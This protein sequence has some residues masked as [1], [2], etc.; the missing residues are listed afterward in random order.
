MPASTKLFI[1]FY[2]WL[3]L[4]LLGLSSC[5]S[6]SEIPL[7]KGLTIT[8]TCTIKKDTFLLEGADSLDMPAIT[9][10][11][12]NITVDF[13][14]A[15]IM[16]S[17]AFGQPDLFSG[18]GISVEGYGITVKN[19]IVRGYKVGLMAENVDS[20]RIINTDFS[21][22]FRQHLKSKR[23]RE[24]LSDWLSYHRNDE[25]EWLRYG[26]G[27]YLKNCD[28]ALVKNSVVTGGQNGLMLTNCQHGL[29]YN[30]RFHFNSGIGI[31]LYRSSNNSILCNKLDWNV[32]GYSHGFY[33]RGQDSAGILCYEQSDSNTFAY[34]SATHSGDG[35]FLWAGQETMD[36]GEGGCNDNLIIHNDFSYAPTNGIEVTFSRNKLI[37]NQLNYCKYGIWGGYS[38]ETQIIGNTIDRNRYGIAI[39]HGQENLIK[40]NYFGND[41]IGIQLWERPQ[42]P[43]DWGYAQKRDVG[44]RNYHIEGNTFSNTSFPLSIANTQNV[45]IENANHF[46]GMV[47]LFEKN[48]GNSDLTFR[49]NTSL[50]LE[51]LSKIRQAGFL[52]SVGQPK[53][54][55]TSVDWMEKINIPEDAQPPFLSTEALKGRKYMIIDEWGPYDFR[56]PIIWLRSV[57]ESTYTFVVLG[58][59]GNW[60]LKKAT[61]FASISKKQGAVP[62]TLV[63]EQL[64]GEVELTIDLEFRGMP[65]TTQFGEKLPKGTPYKFSFYRFNKLINWEVKWYTYNQEQHPLDNYEEFQE[66]KKLPTNA[67]EQTT[68]LSFAWWDAPFAGV[69]PDRFATFARSEFEIEPGQYKI[70]IT[71]DDGLKCY[72]DGQLI[73][74]HWDIHV[75]AT[76]EVVVE[77]GGKHTLELEHFEGGGFATLSFNLQPI[78][79][80]QN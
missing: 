60:K 23:E 14:G 38:Y 21:Y 37:N 20:L 11:G 27:I 15:V 76:D 13:N 63:A 78:K 79:L 47:Q 64:P 73:I 52:A 42:Q 1:S 65:I 26:A 35:F 25:D 62:T 8:K 31:G 19:V 17:S 2:S 68:D 30:N 46:S 66:L 75:P 57:E 40:D 36:S 55:D 41:T 51:D 77:L 43:E 50:T 67:K 18:L 28:K 6:S 12:D 3:T 74:D 32:R 58:P 10:K 29:F 53:D 49:N 16:G 70:S 80:K 22:N 71:S 48:T 24:D 69:H 33:A 56:R 9:I 59:R 34:N 72:L 7:T 45:A 61:G 44:S 39:E 5:N 54:P 4:L